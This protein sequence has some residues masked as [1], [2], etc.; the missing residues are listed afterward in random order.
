MKPIQHIY[1]LLAM[2][3][4]SSPALKAQQIP[5]FN[6][7]I[8]NPYVYNPARAGLSEY[9]NLFL[10]QKKQWADIPNA[11]DTKIMTFDMP[12]MDN[13]SGVGITLFADEMHIIHKFGASFTYAYHVPISDEST[14]SMG[15]SG[16]FLNQRIDFAEANVQNPNDEALLSRNTNS[17]TFDVGFG[18]HY[19]FKRLELDLAVP[20]LSNTNA[21]YL[22]KG[23]KVATFELIN[24]WLGS[25]RYQIPIS[26]GDKQELMLEPVFMVR[27]A[28][29]LPAQY[30]ANLLFRWYD[31]FWI[32]G[33]YRSGANNIFASSFNFSGGFQIS[34]YLVASYTYEAG[35]RNKDRVSFGNSHE[36]AV[37]FK[38]GKRTKKLE[39]EVEGLKD[40]LIKVKEEI[41]EKDSTATDK[42]KLQ[43]ADELQAQQ[44]LMEQLE[45]LKKLKQ[46]EELQR[47]QDLQRLQELQKLQ[48]LMELQKAQA[49]KELLESQQN[50]S[51]KQQLSESLEKGESSNLNFN[52]VGAVYFEV[53]SSELSEIAKAEL[54]AVQEKMSAKDRLI[55]IYI[56]G[57]ASIE[58]NEIYNMVL[59]NRRAISVKNYLASIGM[60]ESIVLP[61]PYGAENP[62]TK[63]QKYEE[64]R[65]KNRRVDV[66]ILAE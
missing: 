53:N 50:D 30:D 32:G 63:D 66:F 5:V 64:D 48:E 33:G 60:P 16:G 20:Q 54:R 11:P 28:K 13:K 6:Q 2:L 38:F 51:T 56:A 21:R 15:L 27:A 18:A 1:I 55:T 25:V 8:F 65:E 22:D 43:T 23:G 7:Y 62:I 3:L 24:H 14:F 59:S 39:I 58:G 35:A 46:L 47:L 10:G 26:G 42:E 4:L 19:R 45:M 12:I 36:F 57:N 61:I 40:R 31:R 34:D 49:M 52:K 17:N 9:G 37:G 44:E 29:G 41:A